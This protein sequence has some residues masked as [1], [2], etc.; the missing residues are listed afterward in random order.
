VSDAHSQPRPRETLDRC[1]RG[2]H[3]GDLPPDIGDLGVEAPHQR[4]AHRARRFPLR[5]EHVAVDDQ[6]LVLA[7]QVRQGH[8]GSVLGHEMV[9]APD[10][11]ARRQLTAERRDPLD[12]PAQFD[13]LDE[14]VLSSA[15]IERLVEAKAARGWRDLPVYSDQSGLFTKEYVSAE[16]ADTPA[17][18]VFSRRDGVIR[19]FWSDEMTG[20]MAD[21]GQD[22]RGAIQLDPL[23]LVLDSTPDGRGVDWHPSLT[24]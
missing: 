16:D 13:L 11:S 17:Y 23:W 7:E 3:D 2:E 5:P 10:L 22:P 19:H 1:A 21:P 15:P 4:R 6:R 20:E 8:L 14:Q 9:V 12:I 24:Y 18:N